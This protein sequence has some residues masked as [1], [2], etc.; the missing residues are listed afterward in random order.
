LIIECFGIRS[1]NKLTDE[2]KERGA[3]QN[4]YAI[5]TNQIYKYGFGFF[6]NEIKK[7]LGLNPK[8]NIRDH[9]SDLNLVLTNLGETV[10]REL[11]I[12]KDSQGVNELKRDT[13]DAGDI[14]NNTR[15]EID[16]KL[17]PNLIKDK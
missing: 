10:A 13:K 6:A 14:M 3:R 5:L 2:W 4:D 17:E 15:K 8:A 12:N 11:H 7:E 1:R 16:A 9:M